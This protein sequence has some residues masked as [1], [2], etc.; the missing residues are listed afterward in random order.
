M[1]LPGWHL[2]ISVH[3]PNQM[4]TGRNTISKVKLNYSVAQCLLEIN[5]VQYAVDHLHLQRLLW[6][7][8]HDKP[9]S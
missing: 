1:E 4:R 6:R 5:G 7:H 9:H 8:R 2:Y 3:S